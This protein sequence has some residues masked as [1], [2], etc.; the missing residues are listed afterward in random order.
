MFWMAIDSAKISRLH[1]R[2]SVIGARNNPMMERGPKEMSEIRQPATM[3]TGRAM[4]GFRIREWTNY[5]EEAIA[6][7]KAVGSPQNN[8]TP[9]LIFGDDTAERAKNGSRNLQEGRII[10]WIITAERP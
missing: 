4:A 3:T 7:L 2:A 5:T 10:Y 6:G 9:R 1:S 8:L